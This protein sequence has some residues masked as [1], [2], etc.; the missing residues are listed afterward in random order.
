[1]TEKSHYSNGQPVFDLAGHILT[2]YFRNGQIKARGLSVDGQM[3][4]E[5]L[6][7]RES[8]QLWQVGHFKDHRKQGSWLRYSREG[9]IEYNETFDNDKLIK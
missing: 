8:G 4:G 1:M 6:F 9:V 2:Y 3:Q 5:W 7:Y